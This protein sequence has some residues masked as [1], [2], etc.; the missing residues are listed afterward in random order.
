MLWPSCGMA[1]SQNFLLTYLQLANSTVEIIGHPDVGAIEA[2]ALGSP[3]HGIGA[4][5]A[6]VTGLE[7]E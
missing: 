2:D 3:A 4:D 1:D 5:K 6:A 7:L